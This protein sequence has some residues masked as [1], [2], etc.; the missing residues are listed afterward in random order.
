MSHRKRQA[1]TNS[2]IRTRLDNADLDE[3][4]DRRGR[5]G[6]QYSHRSLMLMLAIA[7]CAA[8]RSLRAIEDLSRHLASGLRSWIRGRWLKISDTKIRDALCSLR[9]SDMPDHLHRQVYAEHRRRNLKPPDWLP[10]GAVAIDGKCV[11]CVE[12]SDHPMVQNVDPDE[13]EPYGK[14]M[15]HRATLV[16]SEAP[17]CVHQQPIPG[18]TNEIGAMPTTL[19][20]LF[21][22]YSRTSLFELIM[23]DS[24]NIS[25][26]VADQ[27]TRR[28]YNYWARL[29]SDQPTLR[30]EAIWRLGAGELEHDYN[31][32]G[33][34][35]GEHVDIE[36]EWTTYQDSRVVTYKLYGAILSG[37]FE[38]WEHARQLIRIDRFVDGKRCGTRLFVT[39]LNSDR[40]DKP[41]HWC[42]LARRYWRCENGNHWTCDY[43][44]DE[45]ADQTPWST[46]PEAILVATYFRLIGLNT[47]AVLRQLSRRSRDPPRPPWK[48]V[49]EY[50]RV[51]FYTA[52]AVTVAAN[53]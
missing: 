24:G 38:N 5:R 31:F 25:L 37:G 16:S 43:L 6:R 47:L 45:D 11:G 20:A 44:F 8:C 50:A 39:S 36:A 15:V 34:S 17:V 49:V 33:E 10:F 26:G 35:S 46:D 14:M 28:G 51:V 4:P 22:A 40:L 29:Q 21:S 9:W 42:R 13:G 7:A 52:E 18:D 30:R 1:V 19:E 3:L 27:I 41:T 48:R 2:K 32:G 53:R 23:V 12:P